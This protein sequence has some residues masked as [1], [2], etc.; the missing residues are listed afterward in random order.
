MAPARI[1]DGE[2]VCDEGQSRVLVQ[3]DE[4]PVEEQAEVRR[5]QEEAAAAPPPPHGAGRPFRDEDEKGHQSD[6]G[7]DQQLERREGHDQEEP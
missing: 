7:R 6:E 5:A 2:R 1:G 3:C 4:Q